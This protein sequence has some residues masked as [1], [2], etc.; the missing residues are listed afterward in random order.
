MA[1]IDDRPRSH[2]VLIE[3]R[4]WRVIRRRLI[5]GQ[6]AS[7]A[8]SAPMGLY[9]ELV[10]TAGLDLGPV[11]ATLTTLVRVTIG[12]SLALWLVAAALGRRFCRRALVPVARMSEAARAMGADERE[13][14]LPV[15]RTDDELQDL[16]DAFNGLLARLQ[17]A[18]ERQRRFT[19]DASHQL[20]TPLAAL[21][22][23]IEVALRR[24][25]S[26]DEYRRVLTLVHDRAAH[27]GQMVEM[28][29]FLSR[30]DAEAE[31]PD[32]ETLALSAW[33]DS[34]RPRWSD[35]PRAADLRFS[36]GDGSHMARVHP[37]LLGQ[38]LDNLIDNAC[39]YSAAGT[40]IT[41][42]IGRESGLV[43]LAVEDR[44]CGIDA[45]D[46]PHIFEP[47]YRSPRARLAGSGGVGLGLS[48]AQ[49]IAASFH[50]TLIARSE[51]GKGS[52]FVLLLP[53][54]ANVL[55]ARAETPEPVA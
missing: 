14:R 26:A 35:D 27:L 9:P 38:L 36:L 23:Q 30:A 29:L 20:R 48:V 34:Q 16:G 55:P 37:P 28:L 39:K 8:D 4:P 49:R 31:L 12:L 54:A 18:F 50:G 2:R 22:G 1:G 25:R 45:E 15:P 7:P 5:P 44:G 42:R 47:F 43:A 40:P 11:E 52:C 13:R 51:R 32:L 3:G 24:E 53:E 17:E 10:L 21:L 46:L 41:V 6:G 33:I 19:G